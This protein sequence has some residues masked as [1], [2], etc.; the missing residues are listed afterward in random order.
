[1]AMAQQRTLRI[2]T[3]GSPLALIQA[4]QAAAALEDA[5][6]GLA[7]E[8][9]SI[10]TSGDRITD[11]PLSEAGGKGLFTKE[12]EEALLAGTIDLAVHSMK[13][14]PTALPDGLVIDCFLEREDP[15]DALIARGA[16]S[17]AALP[18]GAVIGSASLRRQAQ[19]RHRRP[20]L[21]VATLRGNVETRLRKVF[22]GEVDATLLAVAGLKR[23]GLID[24]A[25][26]ILAPEEILPAVAQ[27]AIGLERRQAD[28]A[29]AERFA[30]VAHRTTAICVAAERGLLAALDGSCRTP[31]AALAELLADG[32]LRLRGEVLNP[33]GQQCVAVE[34]RG[35]AADAERLGRDAGEELKAR[36]GTFLALG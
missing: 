11:R 20:D 21:K 5:H 18:H 27:G 31:I 17:I 22:D 24:R 25:A 4:R 10:R 23:L 15:R 30:A 29:L 28:V 8:L 13:D 33:D 7:T 12:I 9:V 35:A 34:R 6:P 26:A 36:G 14:M 1:M 19:L 3:R 2:G 32:T 16:G